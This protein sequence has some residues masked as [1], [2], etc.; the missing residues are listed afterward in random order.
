[1]SGAT[2]RT[3]ECA[4]SGPVGPGNGRQQI[5]VKNSARRCVKPFFGDTGKIDVGNFSIL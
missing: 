1:M 5:L 2:P 4:A 3:R